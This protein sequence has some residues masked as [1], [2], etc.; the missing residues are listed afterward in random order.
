MVG[1]MDVM[2]ENAASQRERFTAEEHELF[3]SGRSHTQHSA[4]VADL[5]LLQGAE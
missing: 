3:A 5:H 1:I 4:Q 2:C